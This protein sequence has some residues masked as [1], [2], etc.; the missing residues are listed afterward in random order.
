MN[1]K[2]KPVRHM[3]LKVILFLALL[4]GNP[5]LQAEPLGTAIS[6]QGRLDDKG[7][8]A[9]GQYS[10][11][12]RLLADPDGVTQI[13]PLVD[14]PSKTISGGLLNASLDFGASAFGDAARWL[15]ISVK[16]GAP[17]DPG[18]YI[19]LNPQPLLPSG[20]SQYARV[21][22]NVADGSIT[23]PKIAPG[24][25]RS[26]NL[27]DGEVVRSVNG[28]HDDV[29]LQ[30]GAN[31]KLTLAGNAIIISAEP[32]AQGEQG[33][34]G[35]TGATGPQGPAGPKGDTGPVGAVGPQG[36]QGPKG[37]TG[38]QGQAGVAGPAGPQGI[39]GDTGAVGAQGVQGLKGEPGAQGPAGVAGP[40]GLQGIKGD[41]G[42][43]G[44]KGDTG[45]VGPAGAEGPKG[46]RWRGPW[47]A[48]IDYLIDD[49]VQY[50]GS[51]WIAKADQAQGSPQPSQQNTNWEL[52]AKQGDIGPQ[53]PSGTGGGGWATELTNTYLASGNLGIG[54]A[55]PLAKL[56]VNLA[57]GGGVG[58]FA[59]NR[60]PFGA[61]LFETDVATPVNG[62]HA[63]FA[64]DGNHVFSV[65]AGGKG[66]F[67]G[68]V[69]IGTENP[70]GAL[71]VVGNW[72]AGRAALRLEGEKPSIVW[73]ADFVHGNQSWL[74]H[75]S[76]GKLQFFTLPGRNVDPTAPWEHVMSL[77]REGNVGVGALDPIS[78]L[79]V[80]GGAS[81]RAVLGYS[82]GD[83]GVF[84]KSDTADGVRGESSSEF[85]AVVGLNSNTAR[86]YGVYGES[87]GAL[88]VGV[89]GVSGSY[90]G[91]H[92]ESSS[93]IS[94][95]VAGINLSTGPGVY[96]ESK[97]NGYGGFFVGKVRVGV[98]EIAG[99]ADLAEPFAV[100]EENILKGSVVIIDEE[101]PGAL[102]RSTQAYDTR[103]AGIVSG[104]NGIN[105]AISLR[106]E[107][108]LDRGENVALT[109]RV[110]VLAD[111]TEGA[112]KPG[113]LLTT[114]DTPGHAMK[115]AD[116][117][118]AQGAILG[119]AMTG[120]KDGKGMVLVLVTLQ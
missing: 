69:G 4:L 118:R 32:G 77:T 98:L 49:A 81:Q 5:L 89:W 74:A 100:D 117:S 60:A 13:G 110:Y 50:N 106:Q 21:A 96:G 108:S 112:I 103:V 20:A 45:V 34:K 91:V 41:V 3:K 83:V 93:T 12:F 10:F 56:Q 2:L 27:A 46:L 25:I 15:E 11:R 87:K 111:A 48:T 26:L 61:A 94:A 35:D 79:E 31:I 114:S 109:G 78:K 14:I 19:K 36:P 75:N 42:P 30:E 22:G 102:K 57:D 9:N 104:A 66:Y 71:D 7:E 52:L 63:W 101:H 1:Q 44:I 58:V 53:G 16:P 99:G 54:T 47:V 116:H 65:E 23:A 59:G 17:S 88:G 82:P 86:G 43:Q 73:G 6:Y 67:K 95:G 85:A 113:D 97:N 105:P 38:P 68:N 90:E 84:G 107:G 80:I 119:K 70:K 29:T 28:L 39:K 72:D 33:I 55:T 62:S 40:T 115:V 51:S 120:L 8:P 76:G 24:S 18:E 37:D 92:G 64:E